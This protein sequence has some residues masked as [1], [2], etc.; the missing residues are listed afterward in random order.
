MSLFS[1]KS[2]KIQIKLKINKNKRKIKILILCLLR[3]HR[4]R[5]EEGNQKIQFRMM[6][7]YKDKK[8]KIYLNYSLFLKMNQY[9]ICY[10][11]PIDLK[12]I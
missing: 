9:Q 4:K 8:A 7:I 1:I 6:M 12:G 5:N 3:Y 2:M 11:T 10:V